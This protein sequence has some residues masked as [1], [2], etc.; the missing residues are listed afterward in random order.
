MHGSGVAKGGQVWVVGP[1]NRLQSHP[2]ENL[3]SVE[4]V[5]VGGVMLTWQ[6]QVI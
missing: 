3:K 5:M 4:K 1:P 2:G 6:G